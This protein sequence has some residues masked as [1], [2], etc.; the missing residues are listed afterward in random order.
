M[1]TD[2]P[3]NDELLALTYTGVFVISRD[4]VV[5][6]AIADA[7]ADD[8]RDHAL[9]QH[10]LG[11][12]WVQQ[13]IET[14]ICGVCARQGDVTEVFNVGVDGNVVVARLPGGPVSEAVDTSPRG[15]NYSETLRC[16]RLI[17]GDVYVAGM[18]RQCYRRT[19]NG[20]WRAMDAGT[21]VPRGQ[22]T[23]AVGFLDLDGSDSGNIYAVGYKGEI[24]HFDGTTWHQED[25]PTGVAL[26]KVLVAQDGYVYVAGLAG[27]I[28]LGRHGQWDLLC[29]GESSEDFWGLAEYRGDI[30]LA[31][32]QGVHVIRDGHLNN[33]DMGI[34]TEIST[35]YLH[36]SD[37]VLYSVGPKDVVMTEDGHAWHVMPKP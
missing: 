14:S 32:N 34:Q 20:V 27:T 35:A 8:R 12:E 24:W 22:R 10:W 21:Y 28:L 5:V 19:G 36:A 23:E 17:G 30:Y 15:P 6:P 31:S 25:S 37:G 2:V 16:V 11:D 13:L 29:K 3:M 1:T 7:F 26:T 9:V 4:H 18:A 33:V